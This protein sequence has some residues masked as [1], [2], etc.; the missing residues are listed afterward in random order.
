M[1]I[2]R[3]SLIVIGMISLSLSLSLLSGADGSIVIDMEPEDLQQLGEMLVKSYMKQQ[4]SSTSLSLGLK[5]FSLGVIQLCGVMFTLVGANLI[6][7]K[8]ELF[9]S[10]S[11]P[12]PPTVVPQKIC[13]NDYGCDNNMCWRTC[14]ATEG[15]LSWCFT[16]PKLKGEEKDEQYHICTYSYECSPCWSCVG[17]CYPPED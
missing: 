12:A 7:S 5:R 9:S 15:D 10:T 4:K 13:N 3:I 8:I 17:S 16:T 2:S 1:Y 11:P 14:N 6:T